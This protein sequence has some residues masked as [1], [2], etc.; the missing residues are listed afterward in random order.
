MAE[1]RRVLI[2]GAG[3]AGVAAAAVLAAHRQRPFLIDEGHAPGGQVYR[4]ASAPVALDIKALFGS[5]VGK[6]ERL[7]ATFAGLAGSVEHRPRTLA[8]A[9]HERAVHTL[10]EG[11]AEVHPY[12]A[13]ILATGATDRLLPVPGWTLPGAYALGGAQT[14]LKD[15]GCLI[16]RRVVFCGSSPLLHLVAL[17]Y[18]AAGGEVA[19]VVDTTTTGA[20]LAA[21]PVLAANGF[22]TLLRG[23]SYM[24]ALRCK[25]VRIHH[26][27][28]LVAIEGETHVTGLRFRD[29]RGNEHRV[30]ADAVAIGF[31]LR[32]ETQL[33]ELGGARLRYDSVFRQWLPDV[34]ADGRCAPG[35]YAAGDG[36][37]IGGAD[38]AEESGQLAAYAALADLGIAAP[39]ARMARLRAHVARLRRFQRGLA[40]AFD[41]PHSWP[42]DMPD[43]VILCRCENVTLGEV[44]ATL[45]E[46]IPP[47]DVNRAKAFTRCGMGR[48]QGRF[49]GLALGELMAAE[50]GTAHERT[51]WLRA[52]APVK[53]V[54][55][56][57]A[58]PS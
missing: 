21:A 14:L 52:Q 13:L 36:C 38:A 23:L 24:A 1:A 40:K 44:R 26:G 45:R 6:Y 34:D 4:R 51:G 41:W 32:A 11:K 29:R 56:S 27:T 5:Q 28:R 12:D 30:E 18:Q 19:A 57:T 42:M 10:A 17:Q 35:L 58:F 39:N 2:V 54:P 20:K 22:A 53:P 49:C 50:T 16:G 31:G 15:Q 8:W 3:P 9:V 47:A 46:D 55:V 48:C 43:Q 7:H 33:A 25:G 37:A